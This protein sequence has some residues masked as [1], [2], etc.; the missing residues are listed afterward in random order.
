MT[1]NTL[2]NI[3]LVPKPIYIV[4]C[5]STSRIAFEDVYSISY[6]LYTSNQIIK[7]D[8]IDE[9]DDLSIDIQ[10]IN[11]NLAVK[12]QAIIDI[13]SNSWKKCRVKELIK[14]LQEFYTR[15]T[16]LMSDSERNRLKDLINNIFSADHRTKEHHKHTTF[17]K[18]TKLYNIFKFTHNNT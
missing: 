15:N 4:F 13:Q 5:Y 9:F 1:N 7:I 14:I 10:D 3:K 8:F 17:N 18:I 6:I 12:K 16:L 11:D 2:K